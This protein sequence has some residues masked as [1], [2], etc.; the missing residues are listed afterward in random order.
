M[1]LFISKSLVPKS[2]K[3]IIN[4]V[5]YRGYSIFLES[6]S[7]NKRVATVG[8]NILIK[9]ILVNNGMHNLASAY[10]VFKII[11][12]YRP[13]ESIFNSDIDLPFEYRKTNR[14]AD[15]NKGSPLEFAFT[16]CIPENIDVNQLYINIE[17]WSPRK[18]YK[19]RNLFYYPFKF[20]TS[21][22][23]GFI[24][25]IDK[26]NHTIMQPKIFISYA[27]VN[28]PHKKWVQNLADELVKYNMNVIFDQELLP[29]EEITKFMEIG[30]KEADV[31][32]LVC[33]KEF[34]EKSNN[35]VG[36]AGY[37][38]VLHTKKYLSST[39]KE[40]FIPVVRDNNMNPN[41]KIPD[42]LGTALY[43]DMDTINWKGEPLQKL[44]QAINK[45]TKTRT[46]HNITNSL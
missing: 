8:E 17:V 27:W 33:S 20:D 2:I 5:S 24:E 1:V 19:E 26:P 18:L 13:D 12:P 40:Q 36:G 3:K 43:V 11:N 32:L 38:T 37:E 6:F 15:I 34:T 35:R 7:I 10:L 46:G 22:W 44:I 28:E 23:K 45:L 42:F 16:W 21:G 4:I 25:L 29:G 31:V 39:I 14:T 9:G 41:E 30:V